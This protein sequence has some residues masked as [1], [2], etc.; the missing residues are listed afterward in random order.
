MEELSLNPLL[1]TDRGKE[2]SAQATFWGTLPRKQK[3]QCTNTD[4]PKNRKGKWALAPVCIRVC[5]ALGEDPCLGRA[6]LV[7]QTRTWKS[8][9]ESHPW[10]HPLH[11]QFQLQ[12]RVVPRLRLCNHLVFSQSHYR[13]SSF[14]DLGAEAALITAVWMQ[15]CWGLPENDQSDYFPT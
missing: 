10:T 7:A 14:L 13:H 11:P 9:A 2:G 6:L 1:R 8:T 4:L 15:C 5:P 3:S 12:L